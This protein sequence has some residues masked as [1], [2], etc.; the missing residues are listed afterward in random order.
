MRTNASDVWKLMFKMAKS[1]LVDLAT[2][3]AYWQCCSVD[4]KKW[5]VSRGASFSV[6]LSV[7]C[8]RWLEGGD[9]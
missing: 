3:E 5:R 2:E 4:D 7:G 6:A 9:L 8:C 1:K